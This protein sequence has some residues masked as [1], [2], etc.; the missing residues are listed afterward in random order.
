[1][2][3]STLTRGDMCG[4]Y[5]LIKS[6]S[7]GGEAYTWMAIKADHPEAQLVALR[8]L[9]K[10]EENAT[11]DIKRHFE[12]EKQMYKRLRGC[13]HIISLQD[14]NWNDGE[15]R[16]EEHTSELQSRENLVCRL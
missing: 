1:M 2:P 6:L 4:E 9:K 14:S 10:Q 11:D 7:K 12:R 5:I 16:S 8:I 3:D 15:P 13:P